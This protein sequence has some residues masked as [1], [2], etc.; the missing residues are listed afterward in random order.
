MRAKACAWALA[1]GLGL[2][3]STPGAAQTVTASVPGA[4]SDLRARSEALESAGDLLGAAA[5]LEAALAAAP[6]DA[7][8]HWRIARDL[9]RHAERH[10]QL[11]AGARV[12]LYERAHAF[13]GAGRALSPDCAECCLYEFASI[14]RLASERGLTHAVGSVREA[15]RLVGE[16]LANPPRHRDA[17]GSEE[18]AL[19]FGASV[20]YRLLPDSDWFRWATGQK[21]DAARAVELARRAVTLET[22]R[23]RYRLELGVALLCDGSRSED[24]A[25]VAEGWRWVESVSAG[26]DADAERARAL[27]ASAPS[28]GCEL[29]HDE[30]RS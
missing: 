24:P 23:A 28:G 30:P 3:G 19:Y 9:L 16:C 11:E 20:Y 22:E 26:T 27:R 12:A 10:P 14:G 13:A 1:M 29:S 17:S 4:G 8:L 6:G 25:R 18:A 2:F 7:Q 5:L 21:S 15:G